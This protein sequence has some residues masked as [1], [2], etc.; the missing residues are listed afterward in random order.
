[1]TLRIGCLGAA[2]IA[3][4][5]VVKPSH[6]V[7]E[8]SLTA[9]AARDPERA[10]GFAG[11]H[12][13]PR[14]LTSYDELLADP[15]IDAV[16]NPL[17]NGLHKEWTLKALAA[18]KHVLCEKPF[19]SNA[20]EAQEMADAA[21]ASGLVLM[22]AFHYRYHPLAAR[23]KEAVGQLG[24]IRS[25]SAK[26]CF[27]LPKK[28]D[29]R[30]DYDL[31]GG[32][33]MD[34]GVYPLTCVRLL[35]PSEPTVVSAKAK[36]RSPKVDRAMSVEL[37]FD[38]GAT[39]RVECSMWSRQLLAI[40]AQVVGD[41]GS[42]KAFNF[43]APHLFNRLTVKVDGR[44]T[45]ERVPGD[46]TYTYQLRA[47]AGAVLRDEPFPTTAEDAVVTMSLVDDVYRAAGLPLRGA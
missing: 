39:G 16:Y 12:G 22:E 5:A 9:V 37:A 27:P 20:V 31:A 38:D 36:L 14:V 6:L 28:S 30:W 10:R 18:G 45:S 42:M 24:T 1:M 44:K 23:M 46:A 29:I 33:M 34:A 19:A 8:V 47:F 21:K 2:A 15:D 41:R 7:D 43:V 17:P 32:A 4:N 25:V 11:K 35:G 40:S 3:P 13:I 26:L